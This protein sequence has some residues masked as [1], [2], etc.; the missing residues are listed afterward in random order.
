[1]LFLSSVTVVVKAQIALPRLSQWLSANKI[2]DFE[3]TKKLIF[4]ESVTVTGNAEFAATA[5]VKSAR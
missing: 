5:K 2:G 1:M 4:D 3:P